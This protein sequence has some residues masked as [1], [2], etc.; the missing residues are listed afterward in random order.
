MSKSLKY[1]SLQD[2]QDILK[3]LALLSGNRTQGSSFSTNITSL[4]VPNVALP[5]QLC[6]MHQALA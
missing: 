6:L 4:F 3:P 1:G 2:V 5:C